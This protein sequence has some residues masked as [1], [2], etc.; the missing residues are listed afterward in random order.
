MTV[1]FNTSLK[2]GVGK[3]TYNAVMATYLAEQGNKVLAIDLDPQGNLTHMLNGV[4]DTRV[5]NRCLRNGD[6]KPAIQP[7]TVNMD[8]LSGGTLVAYLGD[9]LQLIKKDDKIFYLDNLITPLKGDYDYIIIDSVPTRGII[10]DNLLAASD[11]VYAIFE[12][13]NFGVTSLYD[14]SDYIQ[15]LKS[16]YIVNCSFLGVIMYGYVKTNR[17]Q[18]KILSELEPAIKEAIL[19]NSISMR[20]RAGAWASGIELEGYHNQQCYSMYKNVIDEQIEQVN[21]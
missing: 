20:A 21:N 6:L 12:V 3:S 9:T 13:S 18:N 8:L 14:I 5:F 10:L 11:Y 4:V 7:V 19:D 1:I 17:N 15:T 2:G 16:K